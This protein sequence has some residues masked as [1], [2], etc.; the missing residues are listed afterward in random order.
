M[1]KMLLICQS[2]CF[3]WIDVAMNIMAYHFIN[4]TYQW[5]IRAIMERLLSQYLEHVTE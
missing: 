1:T 5:W 4:V 3:Q 2:L